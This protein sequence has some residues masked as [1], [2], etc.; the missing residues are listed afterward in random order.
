DLV[1]ARYQVLEQS[2]HSLSLAKDDKDQSE[3]ARI[4]AIKFKIGILHRY[5]FN[6]I[7]SNAGEYRKP[8]DPKGGYIGFGGA[9]HHRQQSKFK[10]TKPSN[11]E[12]ALDQAL[13]HLDYQTN[14]PIE[15]ALRFY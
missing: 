9:K 10:G 5:L 15:S 2:Y 8:S 12:Q 3:E 6:G 14:D 13:T 7:L 1:T 4:A 11:I